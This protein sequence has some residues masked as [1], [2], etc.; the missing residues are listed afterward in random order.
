MTLRQRFPA[1]SDDD[2]GRL[3]AVADMG[4]LRQGDL[5]S[6]EY[7]E[8]AE[9][10][11]AALGDDYSLILASKFLQGLWDPMLK[12]VMDGHLDGLLRF[13]EVIRVFTRCTQTLR[14]EEAVRY[15][16]VRKEEPKVGNPMDLVVETMKQSQQMVG[17]LVKGINL[18]TTTGQDRAYYQPIAGYVG[19]EKRQQTQQSHQN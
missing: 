19:L 16:K 17:D 18:L 1:K 11:F 12:Y 15:P 9:G 6:R 5:T 13:W 14:Q 7:A 3:Q 2:A 4:E 10:L 8:K